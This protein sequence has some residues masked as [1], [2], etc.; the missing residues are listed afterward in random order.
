M[1]KK[2]I[3]KYVPEVIPAEPKIPTESM[4]DATERGRFI[5][6][7]RDFANFL[8]AHPVVNHPRNITTYVFPEANLIKAYAV[9]FGKSKKSAD[10]SYFDLIK[11]F[12]SDITLKA[13]F[14]RDDVCERVKVGEKEVQEEIIPATIEKVIP[15]HKED[16]YEWKCPTILEMEN[17][18]KPKL[19]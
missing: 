14:R 7:L 9:A 16:I 4:D 18:E 8:E 11:T 2:K 17:K 6:S 12:G 19:S 1:P 15:A 10:E 13:C 3:I 5:K